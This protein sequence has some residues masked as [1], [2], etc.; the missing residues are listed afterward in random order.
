MDFKD[1]WNNG[2]SQGRCLR[3]QYLGGGGCI[4]NHPYLFGWYYMDF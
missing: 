2:I 1:F 3:K 4:R